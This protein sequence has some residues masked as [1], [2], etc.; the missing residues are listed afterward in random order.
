MKIKIEIEIENQNQEFHEFYKHFR[1]DP[2]KILQI[3]IRTFKN[4]K[5]I[6]TIVLN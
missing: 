4:K 5:K 3:V 2:K 1:F 6:K